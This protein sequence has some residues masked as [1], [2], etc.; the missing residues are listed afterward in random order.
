[1]AGDRAL[2]QLAH[3]EA[4]AYYGQAL[5]L[6]AASEGRPDEARRLELLLALGEAQRRSGD[7]V[8]RETL[9]VAGR[10][11]GQRGD[12][13]ALAWAA[14]SN[15]RAMFM[16]NFGWVDAERVAVLEAALA[17]AEE[18]DSP[19]RARLLAT[20]ALELTFAGQGDRHF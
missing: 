13:A 16:G 19:V 15:T 20:L 10:L 11:A 1:R 17:A 4:V 8:H 2:G 3:D 6:L 7:P 5:E 14:L 18:G 12:A 9:L